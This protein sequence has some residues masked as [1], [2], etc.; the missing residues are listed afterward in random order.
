VTQ[1]RWWLADIRHATIG[2]N[3]QRIQQIIAHTR[4]KFLEVF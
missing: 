1:D 4:R 3:C 2:D